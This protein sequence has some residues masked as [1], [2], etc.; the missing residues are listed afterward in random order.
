MSSTESDLVATSPHH[1][2]S[3]VLADSSGGDRDVHAAKNL[4]DQATLPTWDS[5]IASGAALVGSRDD[6]SAKTVLLGGKEAVDDEAELPV[7]LNVALAHEARVLRPLNPAV[8]EEVHAACEVA[9]A[10]LAGRAALS[11]G[12]DWVSTEGARAQYSTA[13]PPTGL[14]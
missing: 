2:L 9:V 4:W 10:V 8:W 13:I 12:C 14:G 7:A 6:W 5:E 3:A 11:F 1:L